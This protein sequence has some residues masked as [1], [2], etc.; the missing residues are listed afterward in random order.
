MKFQLRSQLLCAGLL[1]AFFP[2]VAQAHPGHGHAHGAVQGFAHPILGLDH[3]AAMIAIGLFAAVRGG[4]TLWVAPLTS[5]GAMALGAM[6][7]AGGIVLPGVEAGILASVFVF[8]ILAASAARLPLAAVATL[9]AVFGLLHGQAHG[10]EMPANVSGLAYGAG[11][12]LA[13]ALLQGAAAGCVLALRQPARL[14]F[15]R[16]AGTAVALFGVVLLGN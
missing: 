15:A 10:A 4:R 3:L 14:P 5:L 7:G 12:L 16:C 11:F 13:C 6:L 2:A 1:G 8:A 9:A